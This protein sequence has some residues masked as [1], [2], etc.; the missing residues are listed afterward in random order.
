MFFHFPFSWCPER[1]KSF[2][3]TGMGRVG[4]VCGNIADYILAL[5]TSI[6]RLLARLLLWT[7][8]YIAPINRFRTTLLEGLVEG[9]RFIVFVFVKLYPRDSLSYFLSLLISNSNL[10]AG[11]STIQNNT[12][13][14]RLH[15]LT[16]LNA[17][18]A[19]RKPG[20]QIWCWCF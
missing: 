9:D 16:K 14:D 6:A 12:L 3:R 10:K 18:L 13:Y 19:K 17:K 2:Y 5:R 11:Q 4:G 20:G 7:C 8:V 15:G 1:L